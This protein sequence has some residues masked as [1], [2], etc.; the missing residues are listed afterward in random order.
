MAHVF[1][2]LIEGDTNPSSGDVYYH[3]M[4]SRDFFGECEV[5][6]YGSDSKTGELIQHSCLI[7]SVGWVPNSMNN[8]KI[9]GSY[10]LTDERPSVHIQDYNP[11]KKTGTMTYTLPQPK[12]GEVVGEAHFNPGLAVA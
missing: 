4:K 12:Q 10:S 2:M 8:L 3:F 7:S 5:T 6:F 9:E 1:T 11:L